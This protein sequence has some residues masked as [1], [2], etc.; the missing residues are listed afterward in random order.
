MAE[1]PAPT[2]DTGT[3]AEPAGSDVNTPRELSPDT[4]QQPAG[5]GAIGPQAAVPTDDG[6]RGI[7]A[8]FTLGIP[9][10]AGPRVR[11]GPPGGAH[12]MD[13]PLVARF[14]AFRNGR[15]L[16]RGPGHASL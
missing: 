14:T 7:E 1:D 10:P 9:H 4:D 8:R 15:K 12:T 16:R 6:T 2:D 5:S 3:T 11:A 13:A